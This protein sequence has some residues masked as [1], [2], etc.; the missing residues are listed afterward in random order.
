M[1]VEITLLSSLGPATASGS[2][3][4]QCTIANCLGVGSKQHAFERHLPGIFREKLH[5]QEI[6]IRCIG[7]LLMIAPWLLGDCATLHSLEN[8]FHLMDVCTTFD[9]SVTQGQHRA[10]SDFCIS[11]VLTLHRLLRSPMLGV[12]NG[13]LFI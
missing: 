3:G 5:G 6:T 4:A 13:F 11:L 10:I 2:R 1:A 9:Q 7:V 12:K 8:Y